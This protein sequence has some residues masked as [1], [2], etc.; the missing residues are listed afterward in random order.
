[1]AGNQMPTIVPYFCE[2]VD[3]EG[4]ECK[5]HEPLVLGV[6]PQLAN[7]CPGDLGSVQLNLQIAGHVEKAVAVRLSRMFV[8]KFTKFISSCTQSLNMLLHPC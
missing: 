8:L 2:C 1:M 3:N 5:V 7:V 6:E 4:I